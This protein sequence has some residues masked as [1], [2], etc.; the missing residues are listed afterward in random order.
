MPQELIY[1]GYDPGGNGC[2]GVAVLRVVGNIPISLITK[3]LRNVHEVLQHYQKTCAGGKIAG[4]GI[5]TLTAWATGHSGWRPADLEL[6]ER[7][8][9]VQSSVVSS[10]S[11]HG[12]MSLNGAAFIHSVRSGKPASPITE[13]HPKVLVYALTNRKHSTYQ[14]TRKRK[15]LLGTLVDLSVREIKLD[16]DTETNDH[17][18]DAALSAIAAFLGPNRRWRDLH[19]FTRPGCAPLI[20]PFG[21]THFYWPQ[22][23]D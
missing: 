5:D 6:R 13:T 11:M 18:F 9:E 1:Y 16:G 14:T 4:I 15:N 17:G 12:A 10:N 8:P 7:Y 22:F 2:H 23:N 19:F 20:H 3:D 21:P